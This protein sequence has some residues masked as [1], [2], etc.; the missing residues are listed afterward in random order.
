MHRVTVGCSY[1]SGNQCSELPR[2]RVFGYIDLLTLV[3]LQVGSF[4]LPPTVGLRIK[5]FPEYSV[6]EYRMLVGFSDSWSLAS[7]DRRRLLV[8]IDRTD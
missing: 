7:I 3:Y 1:G 4:R 2:V 5:V 8:T 6:T